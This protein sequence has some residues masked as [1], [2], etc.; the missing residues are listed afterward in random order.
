MGVGAAASRRNVALVAL[1]S[2][3]GCN[4]I[5]G[6][7]APT[8]KAPSDAGRPDETSAA[9][10]VADDRGTDIGQPV[11]SLGIVTRVSVAI[12]GT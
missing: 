9:D 6:I 11:K 3:L 8:D 10:A 1:G 5:A 7:E 2:L 4:A 12:D